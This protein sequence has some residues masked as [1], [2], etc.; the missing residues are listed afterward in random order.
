MT[1]ALHYPSI[2]FQDTEA[3]KRSLLVWDGIHRIVPSGYTPQ[4]DAEVREAVQAGAVVNLALDSEENTKRPIAS[5][6]FTISG[7]AGKLP[8][9]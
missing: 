5:S 1:R 3:L 9:I 8:S 6:I 2:E 7:T 4:N